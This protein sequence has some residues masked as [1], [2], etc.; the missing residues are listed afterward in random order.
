MAILVRCEGATPA[1]SEGF[2]RVLDLNSS[3]PNATVNLTIETPSHALRSPVDPLSSDLLRLAAFVYGADQE[4]SRGGKSDVQGRNWERQFTI[5]L[6][7][8]DPDRWDACRGLLEQTLDFVSGDRWSFMF[9]RGREELGQLPLDM[10]LSDVM[11][12]PDT[13]CLLS[14]GLDSLSAA[15]EVAI[16]GGKPLL[17]GHSPAFHIKN[18][19][20]EIVQALRTRAPGEWG[21]P[22]VSA[23]ISRRDGNDPK[24]DSQRSRSF[25]Y[26]SLGA[27]F[28]HRLELNEVLLADNGIVSINLPINDQLV[29]TLASRSTHPGFIH[30]FNLFLAALYDDP[31]TIRNPLWSRTRPETLEILKQAGLGDLLRPTSSCSHHRFLR[32]ERDHCGVCS[33]CIDRRFATIA[34]GLSEHDPASRYV[35]N[36]FTDS[37]EEGDP[38]TMVLSYHSFALK[39]AGLTGE[40]LFEAFPQLYECVPANAPGQRQIIQ[41]I[42]DMLHRHADTVLSVTEDQVQAARAQIARRALPSDCFLAFLGGSGQSKVDQPFKH[43]E[44]YRSV[45]HRGQS[46][47]LSPGQA[48]VVRFLHEARLAGLPGKTHD[49]V[50]KF[51][52]LEGLYTQRLRDLFV[53]SPAWL[54]LVVS[55]GKGLYSLAD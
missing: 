35:V 29:G 51:L 3:G 18:R 20:H 55:K 47:S 2:E 36:C 37:L 27:I 12:A 25:L 8:S 1:P 43:S 53:N 10:N 11:G 30:R 14:G 49:E 40:G 32:A 23:A 7:V 26:A 54:K 17:V 22:D 16:G 19:R 39:V 13:V 41:A 15:A 5:C 33:Q 34:A 45:S 31:P 24:E 42:I 38:R 4:V 46:Y 21:F 6:P 9:S 28:A 50:L 48:L 44:N 52:H